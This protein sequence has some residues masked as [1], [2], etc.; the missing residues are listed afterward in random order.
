MDRESPTSS[1]V[2]KVPC[3]LPGTNVSSSADGQRFASFCPISTPRCPERSACD[4]CTKVP[5]N[6]LPFPPLLRSSLTVSFLR[7][8]HAVELTV[9]TDGR[10]PNS[11][12]EL[13]LRRTIGQKKD[14][15]SLDK[16][17]ATKAE[18]HNLLESAGFSESNPYYIVPQGRVSRRE[19]LRVTS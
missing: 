9:D 14:E 11:L 18:V 13:R 12:P 1:Q 17:S 6:Q 8:R 4:Y 10:F 7:Q 15:Y 5:A 19:W 3:A 16:K 2:S